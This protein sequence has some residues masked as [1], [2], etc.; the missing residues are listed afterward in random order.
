MAKDE[1]SKPNDDPELSWIDDNINDPKRE[2]PLPANEP[3]FEEDLEN[4][5]SVSL[6]DSI[7]P[8]LPKE[9]PNSVE[10]RNLAGQLEELRSQVEEI[11]V[12][13]ENQHLSVNEADVLKKYISLKENEVRDLKGQLENYTTH[14]NKL[15]TELH[16]LVE[17]NRE[18]LAQTE[19]SHK[20]EETLKAELRELKEK[21]VQE[22]RLLK[23]SYEERGVF[24][25]NVKDEA[26]ALDRKRT[27]W[28][29]QLRADLNKIRLKEK[30]LENKNEFLK[31]DMQAL[32][33]SKDKH[34]VEIKKKNDALELELET[35][36]ERIRSLNTI[37]SQM[38][39]KKARLIETLKL[40]IALL[41]R[42]DQSEPEG[43]EENR[44]A[45]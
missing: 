22:L 6:E 24:S 45:G 13:T 15:N 7:P 27:Q 21:H 44:K 12:L 26:E 32:L 36:E 2:L 43:V 10:V 42:L 9:S 39:T 16:S 35:L 40:A 41:E 11:S 5:E 25:Q 29:E 28:Q 18:L 3:I 14:L 38:D 34:L 33:D 4:L 20:R 30:E 17:N 31:R 1:K 19:A 23:E 8:K 37:L